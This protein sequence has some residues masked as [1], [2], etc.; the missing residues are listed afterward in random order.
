MSKTYWSYRSLPEFKALR[1]KERYKAYR[2]ADKLSGYSSKLMAFTLFSILFV[3]LG[4]VMLLAALGFTGAY[5][6]Y[7]PIALYFIV[8]WFGITKLQNKYLNPALKQVI[9]ENN[10]NEYNKPV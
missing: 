4:G 7:P 8:S 3:L 5:L 9:S 1:Y 2:K 6:G 10:Q